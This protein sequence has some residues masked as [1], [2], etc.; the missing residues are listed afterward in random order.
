MD[1]DAKETLKELVFHNIHEHGVGIA[2]RWMNEVKART[3]GKIHF[4]ESS[5]EDPEK[6]K[7]ADIVRDVPAGNMNYRLLNLI[8]IPFLFPSSTVGTRVIAQLYAEFTE[9]RNEMSDTK[10]VGLGTGALMAIFSSRRWG[11]IRSLEDLHGARI[12]SLPPID[13]F[14]EA[15][16]ARPLQVPYLKISQLLA[17]GEL[18]ATVLGILPARMFRLAEEAAPYAT[19]F[20]NRSI[21]MHPMR[22]YMK[23]E[24]WNRLSSDVQEIIESLGPAGGDCWFATQAG[25]DAD[26]SLRQA[27]EYIIK[28]GELINIPAE[29]LERWRRRI[30]PR[31]DVVLSEVETAGLPGRRFF[32]R[33]NELVD[34]YS[35]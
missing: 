6:I 18:D 11:P 10:V 15:L 28:N 8:Q 3:G 25:P 4:R 2:G 31:I 35:R 32:S 24:T 17:A 33:M 19:V 30:Q 16:G 23:W 26:D 13:G 9:L 29:E 7:A 1:S 14:I 12:R 22:L 27:L 5:G 34:A 20:Q 21:S